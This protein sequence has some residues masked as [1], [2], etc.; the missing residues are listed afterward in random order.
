MNAVVTY[1]FGKNTELLREPLVIDSEVDYICVTDQSD[2]KSEHWRCVIDTIPEAK[3]VRDKM[4][5]V[6]YNPFK[7]TDSDNVIVIDG[8]IQISSSIL[9]LFKQINKSHLLIKM[10]RERHCLFDELNAWCQYRQMDPNVIL[11]FY[12]M[13]STDGIDLKNNFLIESCI[14]GFH[15]SPEILKICQLNLAY[16]QFLGENGLLCKTNQ[17][18]FTY[19]IEKY[20]IPY[21]T[22]DQDA[23]FYRFGHNTWNRAYR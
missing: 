13:A 8:T 17:C 22:L 7:Y 9:P 18:P 2:L 4:P 21:Q 1:I 23:Y 5:M 6:K 14:I 15:K 20:R 12:A 16:M 11:K 19:L 10:H 3:C